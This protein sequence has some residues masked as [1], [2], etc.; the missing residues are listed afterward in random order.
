MESIRLTEKN[1]LIS[2][3]AN[4]Y[5]SVVNAVREHA[6]GLGLLALLLLFDA[7]YLS[8]VAFVH[9]QDLDW[10]GF[11]DAS[12]RVFR[13]QRIYTDFTF[14]SGPIHIYWMVLFYLIAGY[15]KA[16][17]L[18]H[19]VVTDW[20]V[21][22]STFAATYRRIP[23]WACVITT[24]TSMASYYWLQCHPYYDYTGHLFGIMG[25]ALLVCRL[26]FTNMNNRSVFWTG[27]ALGLM[28]M[29]ALLSKINVGG[30]YGLL[31]F[32]ILLL[33]PKKIP[34]IAGYC[35]GNA[36]ALIAILITLPSIPDFIENILGYTALVGNRMVRLYLVPT[37]L[38]NY[39]VV[40]LFAVWFALGQKRRQNLPLF[41]L[42]VGLGLVELYT[43]NTGS[44]RGLRYIPP[45]GIF[46]GTGLI[47]L[48]RSFANC[49][50]KKEKRRHWL[51]FGLF[52]L[53]FTYV[54]YYVAHYYHHVVVTKRGSAVAGGEVYYLRSKPFDGW[55]Y[56]PSEGK[57]LDYIV[58]YIKENV[59]EED[60]FLIVS[61]RQIV[62]SLTGRDSFRGVSFHWYPG[63]TPPPGPIY[64]KVR[65]AI[66]GNPPDWILTFR[67]DNDTHPINGIFGY[68]KVPPEMILLG[69]ESVQTW[70]EEA[71]LKKRK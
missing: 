61:D 10:G 13:G 15:G 24:F 62:Y 33:A 46:L 31:F 71:L 35:A 70:E 36:I 23:L 63:T 9:F 64:T 8:R 59:P 49:T 53:Y 40:P 34:S 32:I 11:M 44:Y 60:S 19:L 67:E 14:N 54:L 17:I 30:I 27:L 39:V 37:W 28:P 26:P 65:K 2:K 21:G 68:L 22:I 51:A 66:L 6:Y 42:F 56:S 7:F 47:L 25:A 57:R 45:M 43:V 29:L 3:I 48:F 18:L 69:Y 41:A 12:W 16:G 1:T 58:D 55:I 20:L 38:K 52:V 50:D 4:A 5:A